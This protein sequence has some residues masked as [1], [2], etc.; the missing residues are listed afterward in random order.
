MQTRNWQYDWLLL[1]S[2]D[3]KYRFQVIQDPTR[4]YIMDTL[5]FNKINQHWVQTSNTVAKGRLFSFT[6]A[7]FWTD[8]EK[9]EAFSYLLNKIRPVWIPNDPNNAFHTLKW[10][11]E[12]WKDVQIEAKVWSAPVITEIRNDVRNVAFELFSENPNYQSQTLKMASWYWW[13]YWWLALWISW[14][15]FEEWKALDEA[16]AQIDIYN[17]WNH[18]ATPIIVTINWNIEKP[19]IYNID[20]NQYYQLTN[21]TTALIY[22]NTWTKVKVEDWSADITN[23]RASWSF[24]VFLQNWLNRLVI[25]WDNFDYSQDVTVSIQY[26]YNYI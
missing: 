13:D 8:L 22:D 7:I 6:M 18:E 17:S 26:R 1:S 4:N 15:A 24:D 23:Y 19:K 10:T 16:V 20:T 9:Q 5:T 21:N 3:V 25:T 12:R 14:L 2:K 11:D